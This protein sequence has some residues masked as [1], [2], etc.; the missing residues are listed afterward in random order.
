MSRNKKAKHNIKDL[1]ALTREAV[2]AAKARRARV[3]EDAELEQATGG[4]VAKA[5]V[6]SSGGL[7]IKTQTDGL[8][9]HPDYPWP[10]GGND[11][12]TI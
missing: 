11:D 7:I 5:Q 6:G 2:E 9:Y 4:I 1:K 8:I 10:G 12:D 3:L